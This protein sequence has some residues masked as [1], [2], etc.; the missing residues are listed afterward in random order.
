MAQREVMSAGLVACGVALA[1]CMSAGNDRAA[2]GGAKTGVVL[3]DVGQVADR[4][5]RPVAS[6]GNGWKNAPEKYTLAPRTSHPSIGNS[7]SNDLTTSSSSSITRAGVG[8]SSTCIP[9][10]CWIDRAHPALNPPIG[11]AD[12]IA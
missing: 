12:D 9:T 1:G 6:S 4:S 7:A 11:G 3:A 5:E 10:A 2:V 8:S